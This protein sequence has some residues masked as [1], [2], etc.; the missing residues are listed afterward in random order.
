M[1]NAFWICFLIYRKVAST[2]SSCISVLIFCDKYKNSPRCKSKERSLWISK[3]C[4]YRNGIFTAQWFEINSILQTRAVVFY[5][6]ILYVLKL[7][8]KSSFNIQ[9]L[10]SHWITRRM[11]SNVPI[12]DRQFKGRRIILISNSYPTAVLSPLITII[13]FIFTIIIVVIINFF[14]GFLIISSWM[15]FYSGVDE[16]NCFAEQLSWRRL[17]FGNRPKTFSICVTTIS[18]RRWKRG[19]S[20]IFCIQICSAQIPAFNNLKFLLWRLYKDFRK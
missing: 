15:K 10:H 17:Q 16:W 13:M 8:E 18:E 14:K 11:V 4:L 19:T 7:L 2:K 5:L 1:A 20:S 3:Q 6:T 12:L 9:W